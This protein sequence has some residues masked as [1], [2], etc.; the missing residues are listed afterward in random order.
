[1]PAEQPQ[2]PLTQYEAL[3]RAGFFQ[4]IDYV[5]SWSL[6]LMWS[7]SSVWNILVSLGIFNSDKVGKV[8]L[9]LRVSISMFLLVLWLIVLVYR[10]IYFV[11]QLTASV[12]LMPYEAA[13]VLKA[14]MTLKDNPVPPQ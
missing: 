9:V 12:K 4:R 14:S 13:R 1:M 7:L 6:T 5:V 10:C 8:S 3:K 11:L 2:Q